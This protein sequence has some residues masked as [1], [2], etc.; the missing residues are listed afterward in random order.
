MFELKENTPEYQLWKSENIVPLGL[1]LSNTCI[2]LYQ[3]VLFFFLKKINFFFFRTKTRLVKFIC[4][5][6]KDV[7]LVKMD[8]TLK[9]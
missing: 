1:P 4:Q 9:K 5:E 3:L 2:A 7:L 6:L 8:S